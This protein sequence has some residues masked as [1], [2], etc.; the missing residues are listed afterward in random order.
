[1][2][3]PAKKLQHEQ[4]PAPAPQQTSGAPPVDAPLVPVNTTTIKEQGARLPIG[5][6]TEN[7]RGLKK[8]FTLRPYKGRI[9]RHI[10]HWRSQNEGEHVGRFVTKL[11]SLL[12]KDV[13]GEELTLSEDGDSSATQE[14]KVQGWHYADV[15]YMY[16]YARI[17]SVDSWM[18]LPYVCKRCGEPGMVNADLWTTE[19]RTI[20]SVKQLKQWI[21]LK[22]GLKLRGGETA[23][24]LLL[25]PIRFSSQLMAGAGSSGAIQ[26]GYSEFRDA[27]CG[28]DCI[29]GHYTLTD[30]ELDELD[31]VDLLSIDRQAGSIAAGPDMRTTVQCQTPRCGAPVVEAFDWTF[32]SFFDSSVPLSTLVS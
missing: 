18:R 15:M 8:E 3:Q 7:G 25:R 26:L 29:G 22:N 5:M 23:K 30:A 9:D 10:A 14:L 27:V 31:K 24:R 2:S 28:V 16:L 4:T 17:I 13:G 21:D 32:D 20:D 11:I 6:L 12:A 1:M 19:V